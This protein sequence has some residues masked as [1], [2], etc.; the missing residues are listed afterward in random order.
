MLKFGK[1]QS[2]ASNIGNVRIVSSYFVLERV[3]K[4]VKLGKN[5]HSAYKNLIKRGKV[6]CQKSGKLD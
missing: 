2:Y 6:T 1:P 3:P 5:N 4:S